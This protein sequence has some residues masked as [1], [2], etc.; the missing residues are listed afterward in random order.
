M[1]ESILKNTTQQIHI[2]NI[3]K[4]Y[5]ETVTTDTMMMYKRPSKQPSKQSRI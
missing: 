4:I 5:V 1:F 3:D 2:D